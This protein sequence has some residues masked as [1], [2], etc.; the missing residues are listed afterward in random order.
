MVPQDFKTNLSDEETWGLEKGRNE[1]SRWECAPKSQ[2]PEGLQGLGIPRSPS[3]LSEVF[4]RRPCPS[5]PPREDLGSCWGC[6]GSRS[7]KDYLGDWMA[8]DFPSSVP[9]LPYQARSV[10]SHAGVCVHCGE[11]VGRTRSRNPEAPDTQVHRG[12]RQAS[13]P[14]PCPL[15]RHSQLPFSQPKPPPVMKGF[16]PKS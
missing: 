9:F 13:L 3:T 11:G 2:C 1:V 12:P 6:G 16:C 5:C 15:S 8:W 14:F 7:L 10:I 4:P